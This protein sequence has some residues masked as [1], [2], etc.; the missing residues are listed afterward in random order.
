VDNTVSGF[1]WDDGNRQHCRKHGVSEAEV[2]HLFRRPIVILP[3]EAHSRG[4][5]R[6]RAVCVAGPGRAMFVVFTIRARDGRR[7]IRPVSARFM[8]QDEIKR[9]ETQNPEL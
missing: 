5:T 3:D 8:H 6:L 9:Y 2:E 4:E 1:D 7:L